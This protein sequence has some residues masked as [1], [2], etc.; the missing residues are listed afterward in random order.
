MVGCLETT[1]A[2]LLLVNVAAAAVIVTSSS[3]IEVVGFRAAINTHSL[4]HT[5]TRPPFPSMLG[6]RALIEEWPTKEEMAFSGLWMVMAV[7]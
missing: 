6:E 5:H 3:S 4:T 7:A 1:T 2:L